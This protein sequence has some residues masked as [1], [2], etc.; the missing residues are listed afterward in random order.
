[1]CVVSGDTEAGLDRIRLIVAGSS[2]RTGV[3]VV[4]C[5]PMLAGS[6]SPASCDAKGRLLRVGAVDAELFLVLGTVILE[7]VS[8]RV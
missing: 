3:A 1:M 8:G 7:E 5:I 2:T 4:A 6:A